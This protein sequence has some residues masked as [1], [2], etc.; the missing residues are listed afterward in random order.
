MVERLKLDVFALIFIAK[1][2]SPNLDCENIAA[3]LSDISRLK[4]KRQVGF[5]FG[6]HRRRVSKCSLD[7]GAPLGRDW[8]RL[9]LGMRRAGENREKQCEV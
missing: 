8:I 3:S 5:C 6:W 1:P 4:R 9:G 2:V 7:G